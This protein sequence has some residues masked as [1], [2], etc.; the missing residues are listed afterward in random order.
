[1][2]KFCE[3]N[4]VFIK[5]RAQEMSAVVAAPASLAKQGKFQYRYQYCGSGMIIPDSHLFHPG[6]DF[7]HPGSHIRTKEFNILPIKIVSKLSEI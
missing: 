6:F 7:F 1:L 3:K 2:I 5:N 4:G